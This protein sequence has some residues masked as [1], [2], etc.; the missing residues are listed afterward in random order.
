MTP[1]GILGVASLI[2]TF[3]LGVLVFRTNAR[4]NKTSQKKV[5]VDQ[6]VQLE[7]NQIDRFEANMA[8][9]DLRVKASE[10]ATVKAE[11]RAVKAE[12]RAE[13]AETRAKA[14]NDRAIEA[15]RNVSTLL[16]RVNVLETKD[17]QRE[18]REVAYANTLKTAA[19]QWP[20]DRPGPVFESMDIADIEDTMPKN[21][22]RKGRAA[23]A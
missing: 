2:V 10:E 19:E 11:A 21:W 6:E 15:E 13:S 22:L 18:K 5:D 17:I 7:A 3:A 4:A 23:T 8:A 16:T 9:F 14:A 1:D 12:A 20:A